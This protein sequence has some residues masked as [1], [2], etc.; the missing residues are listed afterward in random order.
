MSATPAALPAMQ[1]GAL[2]ARDTVPIFSSQAG[3]TTMRQT[4]VQKNVLR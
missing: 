4:N 2:P 3:F 1:G